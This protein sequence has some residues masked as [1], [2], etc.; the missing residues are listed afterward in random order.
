M[1]A[2]L[3]QFLCNL[4][5]E[6]SLVSLSPLPKEAPKGTK[7]F[8]MVKSGSGF[9][10]DTELHQKIQSMNPSEPFWICKRRA[11]GRRR[12][13]WDLW[14]GPAVGTHEAEPHETTLETQLARSLDRVESQPVP[15]PILIR[16]EISQ[17]LGTGTNGLVPLSSPSRH[18]DGGK[19]PM[20]VAFREVLQFVTEGLN[21]AGEQWG[22]QAK[23]DLISTIIIDS[24]KRGFT[25]VWTRSEA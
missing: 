5:V 15:K 13:I 18:K 9:W 16:P 20:D 10:A 19:I 22:D 23:Q 14:R 12:N 25:D 3:I 6:V 7:Y 11:C 1:K 4:P 8:Y 2:D 17:P 21:K 24:G